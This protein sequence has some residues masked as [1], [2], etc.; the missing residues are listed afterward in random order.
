MRILQLPALVDGQRLQTELIMPLIQTS[1]PVPALL[2]RGSRVA[3]RDDAERK[4]LGGCALVFSAAGIFA[5]PL[6]S[7]PTRSIEEPSTERA[8][9]GP[10]DALVES[11]E[12]NIA[13]IRRHVK[14]PG[15]I[16]RR[17]T[18]GTEATTEVAVLFKEGCADPKELD[19]LLSRLE[20]YRPPRVGFVSALLRPLF[21]PI[22][23]PFLP[24]DFTERPYR[25]AD[26]IFRGRFVILVDGSPWAMLL[27]APF[28]ELFI[29]ESEYMQ[30]TATR[31]FVRALRVLAFML[32]LLGPGLYVAVLTV[33]TTVMPG[34]L[35]IAVSS[36]RQSLAFPILTETILMLVVLDVMAEATTAM[37]GVLGPAISIV[38][39]L[40]VGQAAV[41]ANLA[42]NLGVILLALTALATFITP[43][44]TLTYTTRV[45]KYVV[46]VMG[47]V[48]GLVGWSA[49]VIWVMIMLS[50]QRE[51]GVTHLTPLAPLVPHA[52]DST[53]SQQEPELPSVPSHVRQGSARRR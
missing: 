13:M 23:S 8:V 32:A 41:R 9:F 53:S 39:S 25:A 26:Y 3:T 10:K 12:V 24:A 47:G 27:P 17:L 29:D 1:A 6:G 28:I 35:A 30:A 21:G 15:I 31:Y 49:A 52:W 19:T 37:K 44:Y 34:L 7:A 22:W 40:I 33:N 46:L 20:R 2:A 18:L 38:G 16:A 11:L 4:I 51:L 42:S 14:D 45:W 36:N 48:L 43:R 5:L 50:S